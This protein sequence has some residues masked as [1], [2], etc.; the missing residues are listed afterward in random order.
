MNSEVTLNFEQAF[1]RL[2]VQCVAGIDE[3]G[4]GPLAGP[5]VAAAVIF[6]V[7]CFVDGVDDSKK[8]T[9]HQREE[10]FP[11][12]QE[13]ALCVGTGI[14][15]QQDIDEMNILQA[16]FKAMHIAIAS[17]TVRPEHL[18]IDGNRFAGNE[19]PFTTIVD[20]DALC[21]AIAAASIIAK[22]TRDRI[23]V[24]QDA[25][26]P[27]YGFA[28]HKGYGTAQHRAA[29]AHY[30][31]CPIHRRSFC[32]NLREKDQIDERPWPLR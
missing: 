23:M 21:H 13:H 10:L 28:R 12:I 31:L 24:E 11:R 22:V 16:T 17:L 29:I 26:Y 8:L 6:P 19:L 5:V 20:G 32:Q 7:E 14:V 3:A 18:L 25:L 15:G 4:R 1:W 30:G 9:H 27:E 2:G